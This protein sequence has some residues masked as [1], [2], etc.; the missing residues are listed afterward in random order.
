MLKLTLQTPARRLITGLDVIEVDAPGVMGMLGI[1]PDHAN[2]VTELVTG[3]LKWRVEGSHE[4]ETAA[5]TWGFLQIKDGHVTVLADVAELGHEVDKGRA[6]V[7]FETAKKMVETG[8]LDDANLADWHAK[9][10]RAVAR[11]DT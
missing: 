3:V 8:G 10:D 4:M 5:V 1:F 2:F 9:L 6:Q 11:L 7:A